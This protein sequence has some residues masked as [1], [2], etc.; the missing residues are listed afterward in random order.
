MITPTL[1]RSFSIDPRPGIS[2]T[3]AGLSLDSSPRPRA[4]PGRPAA[5]GSPVA[6]RAPAG[7]R[8]AAGTAAAGTAAD[9]AGT[10]PGPGPPVRPFHPSRPCRRGPGPDSEPTATGP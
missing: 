7:R 6:G 8:R 2:R 1:T 3:R 4:G 10:E 5:P 9:I